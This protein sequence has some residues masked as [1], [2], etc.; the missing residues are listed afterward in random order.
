[1]VHRSP[2]LK[3]PNEA[4]SFEPGDVLKIL[5]ALAILELIWFAWFLLDPL[6]NVGNTGL[7]RIDLLS[8]SLP[9]VFVAGLKFQ[10]SYLALAIGE[11]SHVGNLPQRLPIVLAAIG[12]AASAIAIGRLILRGLGIQGQLDRWERLAVGYGL[13]T[14]MLGLGTLIAGRL[15]RLDPWLIRVSLLIPIG[16]EILQKLRTR[17]TPTKT[18]PSRVWSKIGFV[19]VVGPFALIMALG[20]ML[21]SIDFDAIEYHLQGPKEYYQAGRIAFL[22]H[23]VYT[24]M[25]FSIEMLHLLGMEV[26]DDWWRGALVGQL[27]I[28]GFAL[29]AA[30]LIGRTALILGSTRAAWVSG[31]VY[32]TTPW[33]YRLAILPYVEGPLCYYHAALIWAVVKAKGITT[34]GSAASPDLSPRLGLLVGLLAGGAMAIKYPP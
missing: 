10:E 18:G 2:A 34:Q 1:M 19:L 11:L 21:P 27:L 12:I 23:N 31:V 28:A 24:S 22:P 30:V 29:A 5:V 17:S 33:I 14:T 32:L 16:V 26:L 4:N 8:R 7:R 15:G 13:G 3:S 9:E 20:A 25:P 6:P